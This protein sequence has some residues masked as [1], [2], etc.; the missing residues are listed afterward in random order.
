MVE[1]II[2]V[3]GRERVGN[4]LYSCGISE[5]VRGRGLIVVLLFYFIFLIKRIY[6]K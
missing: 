2:N 6:L 4:G 3:M 1:E 5:V